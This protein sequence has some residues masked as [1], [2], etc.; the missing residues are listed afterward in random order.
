MHFLA[1]D[2]S[3]AILCREV[4]H[5]LTNLQTCVKIRATVI[6]QGVIRI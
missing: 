4:E 5:I 1:T 6:Q 3:V 2:T